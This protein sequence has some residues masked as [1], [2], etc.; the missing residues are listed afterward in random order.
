MPIS[1]RSQFNNNNNNNNNNN[2]TGIAIHD[3]KKDTFKS[4]HVAI[5]GDRNVI[6]KEAEKFLKYKEL[7]SRNTQHVEC[8][9]K[10]G[11][12]NNRD[13]WNHIKITQKIPEQHTGKARHLGVIEK[14]LTG[15]CAR[16]AGSA[17]VKVQNIQ[18]G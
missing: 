4:I 3:N 6:K 2:E 13:N 14:S 15:H 10:N 16:T 12:N 9:N 18:H 11:T 5:S 1:V 8:K 17:D 7:K